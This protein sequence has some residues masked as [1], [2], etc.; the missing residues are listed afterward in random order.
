[1]DRLIQ[2]ALQGRPVAWF[3]PTYK[4]VA[5]TWRELCSLL[6]DVICSRNEQEKRLELIGGGVIDLW[7]LD[8]PDAGRGRKY[9]LVVIDEAA[10]IGNLSQAWQESIRP[11]LTDLRGS[12]WFLSTPRGLNYFK[13][14]FDYGCDGQRQDW[15]SWQMPTSATPFID[16]EEIEAAR[17]ELT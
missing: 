9:A 3:G 14:L 13:V 7:S 16:P 17:Q 1:M 8:S 10:M 5:D 6:A 15:M 12:A 2:T 11:T 4:S